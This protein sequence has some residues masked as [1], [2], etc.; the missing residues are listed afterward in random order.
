MSVLVSF[1]EFDSEMW[2][3]FK[4]IR[5]L[6]SNYTKIL[7][8]LDQLFWQTSEILLGPLKPEETFPYDCDYKA[9]T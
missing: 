6:G 2:K 4:Q 9:P 3:I 1:L 7:F 8:Q 5:E